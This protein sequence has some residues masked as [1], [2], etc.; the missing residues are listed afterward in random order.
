MS[1]TADV[2]TGT[3]LAMAA[4]TGNTAVPDGSWTAYGNVAVSGGTVGGN[5]RYVQY[6]ASLAANAALNQTPA[7]KDV[8]ITCGAC[9]APIPGPI[10]DL[11]ASPTGNA[12][13]GRENL[14]LTFGGVVSGQTVAVYRK[15]YGDYP[16]YRSGVG[17]V[18]AAPA[19]PTAAVSQGWT[20]TGVTASA[21]LDAP[22]TRGFWYYVAYV[23]NICGVASAPSNVSTGALDY[24][25]GDVSNGIAVCAGGGEAGDCAVNTPD[26]SALGSSYGQSFPITDDRV[27]FDVGPTVNGSPQARPAPDGRLDF[28]DLVIYALNFNVPPPAL[29]TAAPLAKARPAAAFDELEIGAPTSATRVRC[30]TWCCASR[31]RGAFTRSPRSWRGTRR[32]PRRSRRRRAI[33]STGRP[34]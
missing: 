23:S 30:S 26:L 20:L 10:A 13:G 24:F 14:R 9:N 19:S 3:T 34:A 29:A 22:P 25:L 17:S 16:L 27:C 4:R 28:E 8:G 21:A 33:S 15:A 2:P 1:W 11:T 32:W 5:A 6:R 31:E 7:L 12:G 18:P